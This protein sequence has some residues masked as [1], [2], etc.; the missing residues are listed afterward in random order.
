MV[1]EGSDG[2]RGDWGE[3]A[4]PAPALRGP[5]AGITV[6]PQRRRTMITPIQPE[7]SAKESRAMGITRTTTRVAVIAAAGVLAV[8]GTAGAVA[9]GATVD[10]AA[11]LGTHTTAS[12]SPGS[13]AQSNGTQSPDAKSGAKHGKHHGGLAGARA[14]ISGGAL[15]GDIVVKAPHKGSADTGSSDKSTAGK[16]SASKGSAGSYV[17]LQ[18]QRGTIT[19]V[20]STA[21]TVKSADGF[22]ATYALD[23]K[24]KVHA[25][26]KTASPSSLKTGQQ[27]AVVATK[28][29]STFTA[30]TVAVGTPKSGKHTN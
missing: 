24:T 22:T 5:Y 10:N 21:L 1:A 23:S 12:P 3:R 26:G 17:T 2:S 13:S 20:S 19:K 11:F 8:G 4:E 6:S 7:Q 28:S 15:H 16:S 25:D 29:G 9:L 27:I 18:G 14:L 30:R